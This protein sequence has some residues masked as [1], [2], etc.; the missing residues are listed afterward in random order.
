MSSSR[1]VWI[2]ESGEG[3]GERGKQNTLEIVIVKDKLCGPED[4]KKEAILSVAL[5]H[6]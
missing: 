1:P 6:N 2:T 4:N 3:G 5:R